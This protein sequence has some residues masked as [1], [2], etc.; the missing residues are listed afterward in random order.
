MSFFSKLL[1]AKDIVS[2]IGDA[3]DRLFTSD[4]ERNQF[5]LA[6]TTLRSKGNALQV[7]LNKVGAGSRNLFISGWRPALAWICVL[8]IG[9]HSIVNPIIFWIGSMF[10]KTLTLPGLDMVFMG[11]LIFGLLGL[12]GYRTYEK[13]SGLTK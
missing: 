10:G 5:T 4:E 12:A 11:E 1:G 3:G 8:G 9:I 7:E 2:A 6:M 13:K